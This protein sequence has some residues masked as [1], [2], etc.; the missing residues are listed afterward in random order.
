M[1][2]VQVQMIEGKSDEQKRHL[3][4]SI[5][6]TISSVL[7]IPADG[8]RVILQDVPSNHYGI[9]GVSIRERMG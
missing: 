6:A 3:I 5:T 4:E 7:E 8:V 2:F 9:G 1:P